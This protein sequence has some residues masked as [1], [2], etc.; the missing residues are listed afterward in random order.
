MTSLSSINSISN[1]IQNVTNQINSVQQQLTTGV[2]KLDPGQQALAT[3]LS[4]SVNLL[5][6]MT[7]NSGSV[8]NAINV[9]VTGLSSI[10]SV[11]QQM[12]TLAAEAAAG[13]STSELT[14][15]NAS[16]SQLAGQISSLG[17]A[18]NYQNKNF[19]YSTSAAA[20]VKLAIGLSSTLTNNTLTISSPTSVSSF[21]TAFQAL[22]LTTTTGANAALTAVNNAISTIGSAQ[23]A[24]NADL[25]V[26]NAALSE[27]GA[28]TTNTQ[29]S[30]DSLQ[31]V[32][33]T[34]L[35]SQLQDLNNQQ[36]IDYYLV[37]QLN[38][39]SAAKLVVFR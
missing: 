11:M 19:I 37:T 2:A 1:N 4:T 18:A 13:P 23:S 26:V 21:T 6:Q 38:Q 39:E 24:L 10:S 33:S 28:V 36:S 25:T 7:T 12:A 29:N 34:A 22:S 30:L 14:A 32:N 5:N 17:I 35:Q 27:T 9:G 3:Q 8:I 16:F 31:Q 20:P 15:L